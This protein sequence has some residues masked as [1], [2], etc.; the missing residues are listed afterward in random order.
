[1]TRAM[2]VGDFSGVRWVRGPSRGPGPNR[3]AGAR[4]SSAPW[5]VF[6]D[7]DCIPQPGWLGGYVAVFG[8][9]GTDDV[10]VGP[11]L[12]NVEHAS[13]TL[14]EAP[15]N[16]EARDL[17]PSCN[18]AIRRAVF[19]RT[20]GFDERFRYSFEDI[21]LFAR[22]KHSGVTF[23]FVPAAAVEHPSRPVGRPIDP[24]KRWESRAVSTRDLG[25]TRWQLLVGLPRHVPAAWVVSMPYPMDLWMFRPGPRKAG[26]GLLQCL[27]FGRIVPRKRL[28][29]FLNGAA[30]AVRRGTDVRL[31]VVG[32]VGFVPGYEELIEG[33]PYRERLEWI[34][35]VPR[36][37]VAGLMLRH[38][39]LIQPSEEED[40]GSSFAEAQA[41]GLRVVVGRTNGNADYLTSRDVRLANDDPLALAYV[42]G[43]YAEM[44]RAG[45]LFNVAESEHHTREWFLPERA[46]ERL[47]AVLREVAGSDAAK[48]GKEKFGV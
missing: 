9:G 47:D 48:S 14:W 39:V 28:D 40:F 44:K 31:T 18:F 37:E 38:Y 11:T 19:E 26:P 43:H 35:S 2:V 8:G 7:D 16:L 10:L 13:S 3:N 32:S 15:E 22:L 25:A 5:L 4:T 30:E 1:M 29:L 6:V 34:R 45:T 12:W 21:E 46:V 17:P 23:G 24:A 33:F 27:W 20:G 42:L 41:C 36:S